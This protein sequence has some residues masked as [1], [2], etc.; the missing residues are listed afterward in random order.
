MFTGDQVEE[1]MIEKEIEQVDHHEC[2]I[3]GVMVYYSRIGDQLYF[4]PGCGCSYRGPEPRS[5][6]SAADWINMQS[7]E[8]WRNKLAQR[9]GLAAP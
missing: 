4:N 1:A 5:W 7:N 3:C 6:Q 2:G 9:F 8:E